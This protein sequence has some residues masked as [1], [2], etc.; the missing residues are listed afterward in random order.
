[1]KNL[2]TAVL[3]AGVLL[4]GANAEIAKAE[5]TEYS[6]SGHICDAYALNQL[7]FIRERDG[8]IKNISSD[9]NIP[10][11]C[12]IE[13]DFF[14]DEADILVIVRNLGISPINIP[15]TARIMDASGFISASESVNISVDG[16]D[17]NGDIFSGAPTNDGFDRIDLICTLPP[18]GALELISVEGG[19]VPQL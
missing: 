4:V 12:P 8:H 14:D 16:G 15:C 13:T 19:V 9:R 6:V 2:F 11:S 10:V 7:R 17:W 3:V 18:N 1:M 5:Y